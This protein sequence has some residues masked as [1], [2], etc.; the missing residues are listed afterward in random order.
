MTLHGAL[1][2]IVTVK[3]GME[4]ELADLLQQIE[5]DPGHNPLLPF[6][7]ID[8]IHFARF[9]ICP[10][11]PDA[12][13]RIIPSCLVFTTNYDQPLADHLQKLTTITG[14][15]LWKVF[16]YTDPFPGGPFDQQ[17]R[18][19]PRPAFHKGQYLLCRR[20]QPLRSADPAGC[21]AER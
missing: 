20:R 10:T 19:L 21:S 5:K 13:G 17:P 9:V 3:P 2:I 12:R 15:G 16:S 6:A 7:Q 4:K 14:P 1:S 8:S 18:R 11:R